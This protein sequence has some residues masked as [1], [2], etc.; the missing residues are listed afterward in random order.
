MPPPMPDGPHAAKKVCCA[1]SKHEPMLLRK[2]HGHTGGRENV[3][4][5]VRAALL[6]TSIIGLL[7]RCMQKIPG[8]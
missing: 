2:Y 4:I 6:P 5:A 7:G 3:E 8:S 1:L